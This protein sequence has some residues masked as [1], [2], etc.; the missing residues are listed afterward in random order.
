MRRILAN[1]LTAWRWLGARYA[2]RYFAHCTIRR[3]S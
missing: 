1:T 2:I 3:A